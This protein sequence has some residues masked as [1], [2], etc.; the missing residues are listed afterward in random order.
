[1]IVFNLSGTGNF[2]LYAYKQ[3]NDGTMTDSISS[4]EEIAEALKA[5]PK[6]E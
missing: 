5:L 2:D 6:V 1:M 3:F 4:D